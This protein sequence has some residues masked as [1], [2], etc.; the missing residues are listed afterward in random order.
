MKTSNHAGIVAAYRDGRETVK[1]I[2]ARFRV[3][4]ATVCNRARAAGLT[5]YNRPEAFDLGTCG[6]CVM[7]PFLGEVR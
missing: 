6:N 4:T 7:L 1:Q 3:S 5:R 2:A